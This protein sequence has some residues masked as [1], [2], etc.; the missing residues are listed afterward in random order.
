[1]KTMMIKFFAVLIAIGTF[2]FISLAQNAKPINSADDLKLPNLERVKFPQGSIEVNLERTVAANNAKRFVFN[3][4]AG[5]EIAFTVTPARKNAV[6][7]IEF[8]GNDVSVGELF[9]IKASKT[10]DYLIQVVNS[11][12][13]VQAFTLDLG[14]ADAVKTDDSSDTSSENSNGERVRFGK[15]ETSAM[16]TREI[17]ANGSV[18]F[19]ISAKKGQTLGFTVGYDFKDRDV[20]AFLTEPALQD[21]SLTSGPKEPKEFVVKKNGDHRLTVNNTTGKKIT[22]TLYLDI[23]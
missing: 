8:S 13:K 6:L 5:Q 2:G 23:N 14:I 7:N 21:I 11:D 12:D 10:G 15:G 18:D 22:I 4:R 16:L 19:I 17:P 3:V 9:T 1:M 20:E